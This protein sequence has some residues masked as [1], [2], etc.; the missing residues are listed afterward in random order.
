MAIELDPPKKVSDTPQI[1]DNLNNLDEFLVVDKSDTSRS[2]LGELKKI[3]YEDLSKITIKNVLDLGTDPT[4]ATDSSSVIN[5]YI[6]SIANGVAIYFPVGDY[7]LDSPLLDYGKSVRF[8][9]EASR[10]FNNTGSRLLPNGNTD[11]FHITGRTSK[12]SNFFLDGTNQTGTSDGIVIGAGGANS[13]HT[14]LENI[15][16]EDLARHMIR[17]DQGSECRFENVRAFRCLNGGLIYCTNTYNDNNHGTFANVHATQCLF[18]LRCEPSATV[19]NNSRH[20]RF[21]EFKAFDCG[22]GFYLSGE[23]NWGTLFSEQIVEVGGAEGQGIFP[24]GV[25]L[26]F[27]ANSASNY[28]YL[29]GSL[30]D[31][32]NADIVYNGTE[33]KNTVISEEGDFYG[34]VANNAKFLNLELVGINDPSFAGSMKFIQDAA[35]RFKF[36]VT[37]TNNDSEFVFDHTGSGE[38]EVVLPRIKVGGDSSSRISQILIQSQTVNFN[39]TSA[40][41]FNEATLTVSGAIVGDHVSISPT[42]AITTGIIIAGAWVSANDTVTIRIYNPTGSPITSQFAIRGIVTK[43]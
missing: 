5:T 19:A 22:S 26:E 17:W 36:E 37:R 41:T 24:S 33:S 23:G 34:V 11:I 32:A 43:I 16:G 21:V 9:G 12:I 29:L 15:W 31:S 18:A 7:R 3:T 28:I 38:L 1:T 20:H 40:Q 27:D 25:A 35:N 39:E 14:Q 6:N 8:I 13:T 2:P 30:G 4:G 42:A 10:S